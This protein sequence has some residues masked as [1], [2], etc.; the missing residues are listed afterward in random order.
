[1]TT[2]IYHI[3]H[4][5]NLPGILAQGGLWCDRRRLSMHL[6]TV[7]I[8]HDDL[9]MRRLSTTVPVAGKGCLGDYVP[10][11]L[12]NRSPM[13]YSIHTGHVAGYRGGQS[14]VIYLCSS[15]ERVAQS[16]TNWCFTDGHAVE[17]VTGF[18]DRL[19]DLGKLD[20]DVIQSWSWRNR[21]ADFDRK[22][23]KQAEFLVHDFFPWS[24][25]EQVAVI[26]RGMA[27][28]VGSRLAGVGQPPVV[29]ERS[30]YYD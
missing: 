14:N 10:F 7:D 28:Q 29:I 3:T 6:A 5:D 27:E 20:W 25:V 22:R 24:L 12:A 30:W 1:M 8:A 26:D 13:L 16:T 18:Y 11:Y 9:K 4:I 21:D 2:T 15:A 19:D 23:R 17:A